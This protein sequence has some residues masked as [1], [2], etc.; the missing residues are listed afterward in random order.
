MFAREDEARSAHVGGQLIHFV[1]GAV[2]DRAADRRVPE[3]PDDEV[4][5]LRLAEL[6][7]LQ[8]DPA[9]PEPLPPEF[10]DPSVNVVAKILAK[11][12]TISSQ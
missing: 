8:V 9:D 7:V 12:K 3:V 2:G 11:T 5:G 4:V 1:K 6:G 10:P